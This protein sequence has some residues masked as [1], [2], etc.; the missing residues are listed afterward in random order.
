[1]ADNKD[2][3]TGR[4]RARVAG[5]E[6]YELRYIAERMGVTENE[7][8]AAIKAVGNDRKKVEE[9]LQQRGR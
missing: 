4:D 2:K 5:N 1:M 8:K 3:R 9:Y 7:V 6:D